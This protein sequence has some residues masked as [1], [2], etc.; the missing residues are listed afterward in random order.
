MAGARSSTSCSGSP[1]RRSWADRAVSLLDYSAKS[2]ATRPACTNPAASAP[3]AGSRSRSFR[4]R[5]INSWRSCWCRKARQPHVR[6]EQGRIASAGCGRMLPNTA[7]IPTSPVGRPGLL[8]R[9]RQSSFKI[10]P[11][12]RF[13]SS[14]KFAHLTLGRLPSAFPKSPAL[15][16]RRLISPTVI[17]FVTGQRR[18][19]A[20]R[21]HKERL[22]K[23][24]AFAAQGPTL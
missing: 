7:C 20:A 9:P 11:M 4:S 15:P 17:L 5:L 21:A 18:P 23:G 10:L 2:A 24:D 14:S 3:H 8:L 19:T 13:S 22:Q 16:S 1:A 12:P 6:R